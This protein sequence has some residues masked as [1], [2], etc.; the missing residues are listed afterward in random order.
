[1]PYKG[2]ESFE[3]KID[4]QCA[5][6]WAEDLNPHSMNYI[7]Y[8]LSYLEWAK[9]KGY[10]KSAQEMLDEQG[11]LSRSDD[12]KDQYKH[13]DILASYIKSKGTGLS[14]RRNAWHAVSSFYS[15]HRR[16]LPRLGRN[17]AEKLFKPS[18]RDAKRAVDLPPLQPDEVRRLILGANMPYRAILMV[19]FQGAMSLA[20]FGQFNTNWQ[21]TVDKLDEPGP[22]KIDLYRSKTS[23]KAVQKFYTFISDDAKRLIKEWLQMRPKSE[24]PYLFLTFRKNDSKWVPTSSRNI[25]ETVTATAK[26]V[27]LIKQPESGSSANRYHVHPH[28]FRDLFKSLCQIHG[29]LPVASEYFLGHGIDKSGYD[30]SPE[31]DVDFFRNEYR[32]VEPYL[33][34]ISGTGEGMTKKEIAGL[35]IQQFL[36]MAGYSEEEIDQLGDLSK[37]TPQEIQDLIQKK[38]MQALGLNGNSK[39]KIVPMNE[40]KQ[41]VTQGWEYVSS[42]PTNEAIIKLP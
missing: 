10:W 28:E 25:G 15:Y 6:E 9:M 16:P 37:K 30:K 14:D 17:E 27:G 24:L 38:S 13:V 36:T 32:K 26:R 29:V 35:V 7:H 12:K 41:W 42:L 40:L 23:K 19:M 34:I 18:E 33:N 8:F 4:E 20:E 5:R 39:Q 1:L 11:K 31:Y 2:L 3:G 21:K 22:L